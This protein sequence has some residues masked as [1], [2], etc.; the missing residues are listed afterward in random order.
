MA[1]FSQCLFLILFFPSWAQAQAPSWFPEV[2]CGEVDL[3][4]TPRSQ[5]YKNWT[6]LIFMAANNDLTPYALWDFMEME[7]SYPMKRAG[8]TEELDLVVDIQSRLNGDL[9]RYHIQ[10][11][12]TPFD[13]N[14]GIEEFRHRRLDDIQSPLVVHEPIRSL[15]LEGQLFD[16]LDWAMK[17]YPAKN[18]M[19][20]VWGHGQGWGSMGPGND[21]TPF[22]GR[23]GGLAF[24]ENSQDFLTVPAI[25]RVLQKVEEETFE[26]LDKLDVYASDACLMQMVEVA[27]EIAPFT[28]YIVGSAQVQSYLGFPY[29]RMIYETNRGCY[30]IREKGHLFCD[31]N[32]GLPGTRPADQPLVFM[33]NVCGDDLSCYMAQMLPKLTRQSFHTMGLQGKAS[34]ESY[35]RMTMSSLVA[36][37]IQYRLPD[38]MD[39]FSKAM[40][41]YL[42]TATVD[43]SIEVLKIVKESFEFMSEGKE[44][45]IFLTFLH[46]FLRDQGTPQAK[47]LKK[48]CESFMNFL[49]H[50]VLAYAFGKIYSENFYEYLGAKA[51]SIWIPT[52]E[53]RF[54]QR[55]QDFRESRLY[56]VLEK[57]TDGSTFWEKW[58]LQVLKPKNRPFPE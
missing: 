26:S 51:V 22:A 57:D 17:N 50:S 6:I 45:G 58:V 47:N 27:F 44:L 29:R 42:E 54:H 25:A 23:F 53:E 8:S 36:A 9:R 43:Q 10:Q 48:Q 55:I 39:Q 14:L 35:E 5:C 37:E 20:V 21:S 40:L 33:A 31:D 1:R 18:K 24:Q 3:N 32:L 49:D 7:A 56:Q 2:S 19:L 13:I 41:S 4:V 38:E 28:R 30:N 15:P 52:S 12:E 16:Y 11:S 34:P 46:S